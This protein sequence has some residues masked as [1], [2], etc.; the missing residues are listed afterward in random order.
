MADT[1]V[2]RFCIVGLGGHALTKLIPAIE[3]NGQQV[4]GL[5]SLRPAETF[6]G[7]TVFARLEAAID[8]LPADTAFVVASPPR[9]HFAQATT[10]LMAGRD[11]ILE[12]PAFVTEAEA[13][14]IASLCRGGEAVFVEAFMHRHTGLHARAVDAWSASRGRIRAI[15]MDFLIPQMPGGTFRQRPEIDASSLY[16]MGCYPLSLLADLDLPLDGLALEAVDFAGDPFREQVR[17][18]GEA[19]GIRITLRIGVADSYSNRLVLGMADGATIGFE[20]FFYGRPG[21]RVI[22]STRAGQNAP[23][24]ITEGNAFEAMFARPREA[25]LA[26]QD[27]RLGRMIRV[28]RA[29]ERLGRG[30]AA[31][32]ISDETS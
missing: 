19:D 21:D 14:T 7:R 31:A 22:A 16:D 25:W 2:N 30:L 27:L 12:K 28:T 24:T 15:A 18:S 5:V 6:P 1:R 4:V 26:D 20:P 3:A 17:L 10:V 8:A 9:A 29:L 23:E 11:L 32:R 13:E